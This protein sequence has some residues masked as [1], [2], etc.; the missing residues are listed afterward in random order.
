MYWVELSCIPRII[1]NN[2][3]ILCYKFIWDRSLEKYAFPFA[4]WD[5]IALPKY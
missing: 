5:H 2:I 1:L 4:K 3:R